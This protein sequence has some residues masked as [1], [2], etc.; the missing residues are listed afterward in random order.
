M[1][2]APRVGLLMPQYD[3]P[4][5]TALETARAADEVGIDIWLAGQLFPISASP[6]KPAF[7]PLALMGAIAQATGRSRLGFMALAAPY[8]PA[9]YLAKA[10]IT[11]DHLSGGRLEVGL[12]AGWRKEEFEALEL[13]FGGPGARRGRL[14]AALDALFA[15]S[16]GEAAG[17]EIGDPVRSGPQAVQS[18]H[19]PVWIG[20]SGPRMLELVGRRATWANFARGISAEDFAT[21]GATV[22][23][24]ARAAGRAAG[25]PRLSLTGTFLASEDV[26][27]V[28]AKLAER[29]GV[30]GVD[31]EDYRAQLLAANA[32][33]GT[34]E[35]IADQLTGHLRAG[36]EALV[37]WPLDGDHTGAVSSLARLRRILAERTERA[38][39]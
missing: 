14:D 26:D 38:G 36:C 20:G 7:E 25:E 34:P 30:K 31:P 39:A 3:C 1:S 12:G 35:Q 5:G 27:G 17:N 15:L 33:L 18:P 11:L 8:L 37:L 2:E 22:R 10:L 16:A 23:E 24:A 21:A 28:A 6:E 4:I 32:L 9:V 13:D 29:A 19:P